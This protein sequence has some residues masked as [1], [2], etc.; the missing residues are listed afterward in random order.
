MRKSIL[1]LLL[2]SFM[3]SCSVSNR[4]TPMNDSA[5][6]SKKISLTQVLETHSA[7]IKASTKNRSDFKINSTYLFEE[8][9]NTRPLVT[10]NFRILNS[11]YTDMLQPDMFIELGDER[12]RI[13]SGNHIK[14]QLNIIPENL[15]ISIV[16][17]QKISWILYSGK[18]TINLQLNQLQTTKLKEFFEQAIQKS[19][20]KFP[21]IPDG[22]KKW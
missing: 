2:A 9:K 15:W 14:N 5:N 1:L 19:V 3:A 20:A 13:D 10:V 11:G 22:K 21:A 18:E 6:K 16:C 8:K 7:D 17:S 4:I 12:I